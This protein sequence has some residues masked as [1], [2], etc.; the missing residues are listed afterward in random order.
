[1]F[2]DLGESGMTTRPLAAV[3]AAVRGAMRSADSKV[4]QS[5]GS[6]AT[7]GEEARA[8]GSGEPTRGL[9]PL[10]PCLS[11][12]GFWRLQI[13]LC[14]AV[15]STNLSRLVAVECRRLGPSRAQ[16]VG[17]SDGSGARAT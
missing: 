11:A 3:Q 6:A 10:T 9:E 15:L 7:S 5:D 2:N 4:V 12:R 16:T 17:Q 14:A 8:A 13:L 1:V